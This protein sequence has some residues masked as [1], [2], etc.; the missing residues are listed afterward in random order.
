M[1]CLEYIFEKEK[2]VHEAKNGG[3][4]KKLKFEFGVGRKRGGAHTRIS[5]VSGLEKNHENACIGLRREGPRT[6]LLATFAC[7]FGSLSVL[8]APGA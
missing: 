2:G 3:V 4:K 1:N 6:E 8:G 7:F 5:S